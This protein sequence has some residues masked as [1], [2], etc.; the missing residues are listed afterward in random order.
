M[1][2]RSDSCGRSS[3]SS[4]RNGWWRGK[5]SNL[6]RLSPADLQS[7]PF[8]HSGTSPPGPSP[9]LALSL[10][11]S[12]RRLWSR[13]PDS[14]WQPTDYKS[15]AL[16]VELHRHRKLSVGSPRHPPCGPAVDPPCRH[17]VPGRLASA[18]MPQVAKSKL[19]LLSTVLRGVK[20][21]VR[22]GRV[23]QPRA[24]VGH[25]R[26]VA[27]R[28]T[29]PAGRDPEKVPEPGLRRPDRRSRPPGSRKGT[30]RAGGKSP[31]RRPPRR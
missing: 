12:R 26:P 28:L 17:P 15:G 2:R 7:A 9:S 24:C 20:S 18:R 5:D 22:K 8:G 25:R 11:C 19:G 31:A 30:R 6:R 29:R 14:N 23:F 10:R 16:P 1:T 4:E 21:R 27:I 13:W 3:S